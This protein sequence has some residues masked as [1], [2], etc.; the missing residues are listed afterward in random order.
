MD[1][2][3]NEERVPLIFNIYLSPSTMIANLFTY[4]FCVF[5]QTQ[6]III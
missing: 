3:R 6:M 1:V 2:I 5:S 4:I